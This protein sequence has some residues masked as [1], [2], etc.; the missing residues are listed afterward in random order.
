[1]MDVGIPQTGNVGETQVTFA[2][3]NYRKIVRRLVVIIVEKLS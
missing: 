1:M 2:D 3:G